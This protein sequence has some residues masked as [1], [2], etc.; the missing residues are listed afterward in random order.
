MLKRISLEQ[1]RKRRP[2]KE[3][4][5]PELNWNYGII[6][7]KGKKDGTVKSR[8]ENFQFLSYF[9]FLT[10]CWLFRTIWQGRFLSTYF[11]N[12]RKWKRTTKLW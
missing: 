8:L 12:G 9:M 5:I 7:P 4:E 6:N 3:Y 11:S 2:D 1:N 10:K